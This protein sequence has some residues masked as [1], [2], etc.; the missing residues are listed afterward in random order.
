MNAFALGRNQNSLLMVSL[1]STRA[2]F[3][4]GGVPLPC[5][6]ALVEAMY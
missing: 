1:S 6:T 3:K 4:A 5:A 2:E